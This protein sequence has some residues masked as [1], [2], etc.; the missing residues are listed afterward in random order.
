M[1]DFIIDYETM[2]AA[3]DGAVVD[4]SAV[5]FEFDIENPPTFSDLVEQS[6]N[7]KF[8]LADQKGV[9]FFDKGTIDWW[10]KQVPEAQLALKPSDK[11]VSVE[12]GIMGFIGFLQ[13][14]GIDGWKSHGYCRGQSFDFPLMVDCLKQIHRTRDTFNHEPCKF[15]N[16][17]DVRT[18][19]E[20]T[21]MVR[22]QTT[23]P[24]RKGLIDGFVKHN[25]IHDCAKDVLMLI[26]ARRY[27]LG[28]E[29]IPKLDE[30]DENT[31][32][33]R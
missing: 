14:N 17:R 10:K 11:D 28:L 22:D 26:Y 18:A 13:E 6:Y 8:S 12:D 24:L 4:L 15:W 16:Q 33:S 20:N 32:S 21:M 27:A 19:I 3:P 25:S 1:K 5:V 7:A 9:R 2:G 29:D 30:A 31:V 23:V